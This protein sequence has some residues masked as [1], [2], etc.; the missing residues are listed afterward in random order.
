MRVGAVDVLSVHDGPFLPPTQPLAGHGHL[1]AVRAWALQGVHAVQ[2]PAGSVP[3]H[4]GHA[5]LHGTAYW[6]CGELLGIYEV[7]TVEGT[8]YTVVLVIR[9]RL[10]AC[11][12]VMQR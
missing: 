2:N 4:S 11:Q 12:S 7:S 6:G 10:P 9:R 3:W 1:L 8:E 5:L